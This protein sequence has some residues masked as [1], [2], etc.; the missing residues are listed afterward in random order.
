MQVYINIKL[1]CILLLLLLRIFFNSF[2]PGTF[3]LNNHETGYPAFCCCYC[4]VNNYGSLQASGLKIL[5]ESRK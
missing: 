1:K 2:T 4:R 3:T 5:L